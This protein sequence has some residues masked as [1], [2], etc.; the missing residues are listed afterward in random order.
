MVCGEPLVPVFNLAELKRIVVRQALTSTNDGNR[1]AA[2]ILGVALATMTRVCAAS[3]A[4]GEA[5]RVRRT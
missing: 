2:A 4:T 5:G 1:Q 3:L